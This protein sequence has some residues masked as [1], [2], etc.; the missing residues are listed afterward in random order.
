MNIIQDAP[1]TV[2]LSVVSK[3]TPANWSFEIHCFI[4]C[5]EVN[6]SQWSI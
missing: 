1:A 6:E 3:I 5:L 2:L 4:H